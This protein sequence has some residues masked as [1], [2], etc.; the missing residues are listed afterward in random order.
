M[1]TTR[2]KRNR[3]KRM[4]GYL[5]PVPVASLL[6]IA[7]IA[8]LAYLWMISR[9]EAIGA[10]IKALEAQEAELAE[11]FLNEELKWTRMKSPRNLEKILARNGVRMDWPTPAQ[12]V[13]LV[14]ARGREP[15]EAEGVSG[16]EGRYAGVGRTG[17]YE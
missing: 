10:E 14:D 13:L 17:R 8:A 2:K 3:R 12:T 4:D 9:C 16:Q 15:L 11:K 6:V 5:F 1:R 7:A